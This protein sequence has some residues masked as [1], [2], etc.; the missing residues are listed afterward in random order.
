MTKSTQPQTSL[1][2]ALIDAIAE[3]GPITFA[4][5]MEIALYHPEGGYYTGG[6]IAD[7]SGARARQGWAGDY[8]TSTDL[9][10]LFG[11]AIGR[12]LAQIWDLLGQP[13]P[14]VVL[15]DGAGRGDLARDIHAWTLD[16]EQDAPP[17]FPVALHYRTRDLRLGER[18]YPSEG[19]PAVNMPPSA[20][21]QSRITNHDSATSMAEASAE[22]APSVI[23]TN[24]LIDAFP[25]HRV[26]R[27]DEA[28]SEIYVD[29]A[30]LGDQLGLV[31]TA[32]PL[33]T[34]ALSDYLER[35]GVRQAALPDGWQGEINLRA[36][37]WMAAAAARL[38][39]RGVVITL[40]YGDTARKLYHRNRRLGTL[41]AYHHHQ[42]AADP[43][44]LVGEQD[45][46]AHVNMTALIASGR[47]QG[48]RLAGLVT[49]R[50]FLLALGLR[51]DAE[52]LGARNYPLAT[53]ARAT[54]AG[55]VDYLRLASL[56][57]RVAALLDPAGM[58]GFRVLVQQ[59]GLPGAARRLR[60]LQPSS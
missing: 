46:T 38:A 34:P 52:R 12:Q 55:Q 6:G 11:A 32:G 15:E 10:P 9:H 29:A 22:P 27:R 24:E 7:T 49:Q 16:Q 58:G 56:R 3:R 47:Q 36:E 54:D 59:R 30:P 48:L 28:W 31:L 4:D 53:T 19:G 44:A 57:H 42:I 25:V 5:F 8:L 2:A 43:L 26:V 50:D 14:F 21:H 1:G 20:C 18:P 37:T 45:L 33:S 39:P 51:E 41:T 40:D 35:Y 13:N 60:G 17:G 23:L